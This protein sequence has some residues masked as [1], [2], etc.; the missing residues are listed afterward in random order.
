MIDFFCSERHYIDHVLPIWRALKESEKG[1]FIVSNQ[2]ALDH[3]LSL[4]IEAVWTPPR[5]QITLVAS[6]GDYKKTTGKVIYM[7]HGIGH[8]Y[9]K[10]HPS[11]AG[12]KHRDRV[13]LFLCQHELTY[14]K[15][16]A[17]FPDTPAAIVGTPKL[18]NIEIR[19]ARGRTVALSWHW[20]CKV[21]PETRSSLPHYRAIL[22]I[23]RKAKNLEL[24]GHA[25]PNLSFNRTLQKI[26]SDSKI[27]YVHNFADVLNEADV[28]VVDNSSTAYEFAAAGRHVLHLN[29]PWYRKEINHGIR[30]WDYLPGPMADKPQEVLPLVRDL[31]DHPEKYEAQ[32]LAVVKQ[33]YPYQ[34]TATKQAV[35][36][37]RSVLC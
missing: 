28:Y 7:E 3:A 6:Y 19:P 15:N 24:I 16:K 26:Y 33:L 14:Q 32:R 8:T 4:G 22:Q 23:L 36:A 18:D 1:W 30:F 27:R 25:H 10:D 9:S 20:D 21:V 2:K 29:A 34:G 13:I 12:S 11:Y 17:T 31:L 5:N 37:I 35:K